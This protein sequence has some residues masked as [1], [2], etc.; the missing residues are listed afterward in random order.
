MKGF[1][2]EEN[3]IVYNEEA[4][5]NFDKP[6]RIQFD[7]LHSDVENIKAKKPVTLVFRESKIFKKSGTL[8]IEP[9]KYKYVLVEGIFVMTHQPLVDLF[10]VT[11]WVETSEYVCAL[12]RFYR[13]IQEYEG[14]S[15]RYVLNYCSRNVMPSK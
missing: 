12:R 15:P 5:F 9:G 2:E 10:D 4:P 3:Q 14:Y 7:R 8:F 11:I 1:T 6:E 13:Y